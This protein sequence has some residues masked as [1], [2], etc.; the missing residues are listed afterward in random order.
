MPLGLKY[1][2]SN[3]IK[4]KIYVGL[5]TALWNDVNNVTL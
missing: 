2:L 5:K 3:G 1:K 4:D